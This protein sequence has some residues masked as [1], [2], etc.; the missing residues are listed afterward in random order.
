M[1]WQKSKTMQYAS[2][3]CSLYRSVC[4]LTGGK[5]SVFLLFQNQK[6]F[7]TT[8]MNIKSNTSNHF[9]KLISSLWKKMRRGRISFPKRKTRSTPICKCTLFFQFSQNIS[10]SNLKLPFF[11]IEI[12]LN[13][14][15]TKYHEG[16]ERL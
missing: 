7:H 9:S 3:K 11:F 1:F 6:Y 12:V 4:L 5:E 13:V 14:W 2:A 8:V 16:P 15:E 10:K